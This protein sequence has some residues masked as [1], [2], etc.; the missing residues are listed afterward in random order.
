[1]APPPITCAGAFFTY[2]AILIVIAVAT[3]W[4]AIA[5]PPLTIVYIFIQR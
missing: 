2:F 3:K 5:L 1:L 4:F